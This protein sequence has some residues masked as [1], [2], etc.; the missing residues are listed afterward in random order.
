MKDLQE[1][2]RKMQKIGQRRNV[3]NDL[4]ESN[5]VIFTNKESEKQLGSPAYVNGGASMS[6]FSNYG[7]G[8]GGL[9]NN[10]R[11]SSAS[12]RVEIM[13]NAEQ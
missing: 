8:V 7:S 1:T 6:Q 9:V 2:N 5:R 3:R 10:N 4:S 12:I 11:G 13:N